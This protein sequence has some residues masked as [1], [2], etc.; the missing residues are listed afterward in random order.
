MAVKAKTGTSDTLKVE[1][2][3]RL[4]AFL[5][6]S[7][8]G[9]SRTTVKSYL[10]HN[11]VAVN[12]CI[13]TRF[14]LPLVAGDTVTVTYG[15]SPVT[16]RHPMLRIIFED[17]FLIVV[18]KRN[19]LLSIATDKQTRKTAFNILSD[20]V[21]SKDPE[22]LVFVLHRLDRETSGLMMFA[23]DQALKHRIQA[24]WEG[25][26]VERKYYAVI[27]GQLERDEGV[28]STYLTE[29]KALKVYAARKG[30]GKIAHTAFRVLRRSTEHT[31]LELELATGRKN[32]IRAHMEYIGQSII[33]D[34]KYGARTNPLGRVALHAGALS[35]IHPVTGERHDFTTPVPRVF[36]DLF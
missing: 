14:D 28:I 30:E 26:V 13:T 6:G 7:M 5:L 4:L 24:D 23:K 35:F 15:R 9:K 34:K 1:K 27:E 16:L 36:L 8:P 25:T 10:S 11:Q 31:L 18:E 3:D 32:Q 2:E 20:Y 21:K 29:S 19:G 12:G 22:S 17:D 33:G